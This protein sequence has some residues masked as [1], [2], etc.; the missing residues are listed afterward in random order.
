MGTGLPEM[1]PCVTREAKSR[2]Y[3]LTFRL[4]V[5]PSNSFPRELGSLADTISAG[6]FSP[7]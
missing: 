6:L 3:F 1:S 7:E 5:L 2:K 4:P